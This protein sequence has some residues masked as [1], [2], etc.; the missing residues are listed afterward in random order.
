MIDGRSRRLL[1]LVGAV[2]DIV[3]VNWTWRSGKVDQA[4]M[5]S[6]APAEMAKKVGWVRAG[7]E[8]AGRW[9]ALEL[10]SAAAFC[11]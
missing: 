9:E 3:S 2:A 11:T 10:E 5:A 8:K 4:A 6:S 7:A 1:T